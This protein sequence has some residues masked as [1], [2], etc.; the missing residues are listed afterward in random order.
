MESLIWEESLAQTDEEVF[1]IT[2]LKETIQPIF[3]KFDSEWKDKKDANVAEYH[4]T[5]RHREV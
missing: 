5:F 4:D 2:M 3:E 1:L